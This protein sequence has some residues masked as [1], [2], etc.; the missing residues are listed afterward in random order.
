MDNL[1]EKVINTYPSERNWCGA[2]SL[3]FY[4]RLEPDSTDEKKGLNFCLW[5]ALEAHNKFS[6]K[7]FRDGWLLE[8]RQR[9]VALHCKV[10][11]KKNSN[12]KIYKKNPEK[13]IKMENWPL[14]DGIWVS[15]FVTMPFVALLKV[16]RVEIFF[17]E[18]Y[19]GLVTDIVSRS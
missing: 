15:N 7:K 5:S 9:V 6:K 14:N 18:N 10:G 3:E 16:V 17:L 19:C 12:A 1:N 2:I 13:I 4:E 11:G 8:V